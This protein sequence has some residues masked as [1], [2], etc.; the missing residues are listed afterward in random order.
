MIEIDGSV[1]EAGGQITRTATALSAIL[2]TPCHIF[3]I[4]SGRCNPGL[5]LQHISGI[6]AIQEL[7][8]GKL[9]NA[10]LGS[11]EIWFY[12]E[13]IRAK[14]LDIKIESAG[15]IGLVLQGLMIAASHLDE[16]L[17]IA[18][19]GGATSGKWAAPV[20]YVKNVLMPILEKM[21]YE[22]SVEIERYGY[23]PKGGS[24]VSAWINPC[25]LKPLQLTEQGKLISI[26][27]ISH[28]SQHLKNA[29]V[30]ERQA[31]AADKIL[32]DKYSLVP[33]IEQQYVDSECMGSAI[34]LFACMENSVMGSEGLGER[35]KTA[36]KVGTE[37]AL[38]LIEQIGS[39]APLDKHMS[40]QILPYIALAAEHGTSKIK[41]AGVT[42]HCLTNI[43]LIEKFL[44]VKFSVDRGNKIISCRKN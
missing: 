36:E 6:K 13:K 38:Q 29:S 42:Q 31:D 39:H 20:N 30:A 21:G 17:E 28:A 35:G 25:K 44:P 7:C 8:N 16:R 1:G 5:K 26:N 2:E 15:S 9:Q 23:Y 27:G 40:D 4:R 19:E 24:R 34:D 12:P 11:T 3:N 10:K 33:N 32:Y 41:V 37:A 14:K 22:A 18:V 43:W